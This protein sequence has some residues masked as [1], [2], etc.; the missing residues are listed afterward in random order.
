MAK[1]FEIAHL[2]QDKLEQITKYEQKLREE[3]GEE[4]VLIAYEECEK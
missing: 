2:S 3:I 1:R 4:I